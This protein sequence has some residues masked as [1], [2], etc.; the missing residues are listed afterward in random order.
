MRVPANRRHIGF[1]RV[2]NGL[3]ILAGAILA[4]TLIVACSKDAPLTP[5]TE[6]QAGAVDDA[7]TW[8]MASELISRAGWALDPEGVAGAP[9]PAG[10]HHEFGP[11]LQFLGRQVITGDIV[12][13]SFRLPVGPGQYDVIGLHRVVREMAPGV[14][15]KTRGNAFLQH[16]DIKDFTGM[17]LPGVSSPRMPDDFGF[18]V[19]LAG[20]DIDVWGIDQSWTLVP[21]SETA[22]SFMAD[23]GLER[24]T[25]DLK[26]AMDVA[27]FIRKLTGC[28]S[29]RMLLL[30][31]SSGAATGFALLAQ[32]TLRPPGLRTVGGFIAADFGLITDVPPWQ[33]ITCS[34]VEMFEASMAAGDYAFESF[35]PMLG[36]P[37]RDNPDG[38]SDFF[39]GFTNLQAGIALGAYQAYPTLNY[40]FV[41][42]IFDADGIPTGLQY[43]NVDMWVDFMVTGPPYEPYAFLRDYEKVV[44]APESSP[45]AARLGNIK[46]PVLY[47]KAAGGTGYMGEYTLSQLGSKDVTTMEV[48]LH[49]D[50]EV[51]LDFGHVDLFIADNAPVLAWSGMRSWVE[52][53]SNH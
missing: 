42:G 15:V 38:P 19:Y 44:C 35:F 40:H 33:E 48:K 28:G 9:E 20:D 25:H 22:S 11:L 51:L 34:E 4:A 50:S 26:L 31:Y 37:A 32:E 16:G 41:A 36:P 30:G 12:H 10:G 14:P 39:P 7:T 13:Y 52:S 17:F 8:A 24:Q 29:P 47:V 18:A 46:A 53:H 2:M 6:M 43:T 23:W 3:L 27:G 49:P 21:A 1:S 5:D 45:Y